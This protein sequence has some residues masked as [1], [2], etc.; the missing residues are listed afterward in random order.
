MVDEGC[1]SA[2]EL[3]LAAYRTQLFNPAD[4]DKVKEVQAGYKVQ[5]LSAFLGQ[6]AP[7][8][9]AAIDFI[10]PLTPAAQRSSLQFFEILNFVLQF[11]PTHPSERELMARFAR[12]G[13]GGGQT[14][15]EGQLAAE[16]KSAIEAGMADAWAELAKL[17]ARIDAKEVTSGDMFGTR[18]FLQNNYLYRMAAAVLGIYGNSQ[19]EAMYPIYSAMPTV[20]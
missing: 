10:K 18:D 2:C 13:V 4:L 17:Q 3:V 9:A 6:P 1:W 20:G 12:I 7:V 16:L 14:F 19:Q 11:C 15:D 5:T 8:A